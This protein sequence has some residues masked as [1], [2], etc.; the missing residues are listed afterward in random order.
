MGITA[1]PFSLSQK[2]RRVIMGGNP[3]VLNDQDLNKEFDRIDTTLLQ[4]S[5]QCG[6]LRTNWQVSVKLNKEDSDGSGNNRLKSQISILKVD[7][8]QPAYVYYKG[9]RFE[10]PT[11]SA[12]EYSGTFL[13]P[14]PALPIAYVLLIATLETINFSTDPVL[15]GVNSSEFPKS[16]PAVDITRYKGERL[17]FTD[18]P[19][20]PVLGGGEVVIGII[21]TIG[22]RD[23][24][25]L[26][27]DPNDATAFVFDKKYQR[28][29]IYNAA[30]TT[31][32]LANYQFLLGDTSLTN[33]PY[34]GSIGTV[35]TLITNGGFVDML[36]LISEYDK[37]KEVYLA[38]L[39]KHWTG[40]IG[41]IST[42]VTSVLNSFT[43]LSTNIQA[44]LDRPNIP[45]GAIM[46]YYGPLTNF[47]TSGKGKAGT[48]MNWFDICNG[49][50]GTPDLRGRFLVGAVN[51]PNVGAPDM[52]PEVNPT[53]PTLPG[54]TNPAYNMGDIG[55]ESKHKLVK[56]ELPVN[57]VNLPNSSVAGQSDNADDRDVMIPAAQ[58]TLNVGGSDAHHENKP[59]YFAVIYIMRKR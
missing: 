41:A 27:V 5:S 59:P 15:C 55:G 36:L 20:F 11:G 1:K 22:V 6:M 23:V 10:I 9:I 17:V 2:I 53:E 26:K 35:Q 13:L 28:Q 21:A 48:D 52:K 32:L 18:N 3:K 29:T 51:V 33:T 34:S 19:E 50:N 12:K 40:L 47:E 8:L 43:Q 49:F 42:K 39:N 54:N 25:E 4:L 44:V 57:V 7:D 56:A 30:T 14:S 38:L 45:I 16:L 31:E 58:Q 37:R 24:S 46:P